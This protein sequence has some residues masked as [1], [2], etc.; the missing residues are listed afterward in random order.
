[1]G[2]ERVEKNIKRQTNRERGCDDAFLSEHEK[3]EFH[4]W[5]DHALQTTVPNSFETVK[6]TSP[7]SGAS[8]FKGGAFRVALT[9]FILRQFSEATQ[10][11]REREREREEGTERRRIRAIH[12]MRSDASFVRA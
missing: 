2:R 9:L 1:M 8:R 10:K 5:L 11:S 7:F 12:E 4:F 6:M 3:S